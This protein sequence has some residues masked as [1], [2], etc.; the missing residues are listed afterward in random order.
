MR[1]INLKKANSLVN[2]DVKASFSWIKSSFLVEEIYSWHESI[3]LYDPAISG[4]FINTS[5]YIGQWASPQIILLFVHRQKFSLTSY[6]VVLLA[7]V[8]NEQVFPLNVSLISFVSLCVRLDKFS[9]LTSMFAHLLE[10][11]C[12]PCRPYTQTILLVQKLASFCWSCRAWQVFEQ[13]SPCQEETFQFMLYTRA[14]KT[15]QAGS[16]TW[17]GKIACRVYRA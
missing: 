5:P 10:W 14:N 4:S 17:K 15:C 16:K 11:I 7:R 1:Q 12:L 3:R 8:Y 2:L 6:L 9:A 13:A